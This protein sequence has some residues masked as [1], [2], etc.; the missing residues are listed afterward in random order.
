MSLIQVLSPPTFS[1][2]TFSKSHGGGRFFS[3]ASFQAMFL[4]LSPSSPPN[5]DAHTPDRQGPA[6]NFPP[7]RKRTYEPPS[8]A[9]SKSVHHS[10][11]TTHQ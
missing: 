9:R 1:L 8:V 10:L 3:T 2:R 4:F 11:A 5:A 6:P 7:L